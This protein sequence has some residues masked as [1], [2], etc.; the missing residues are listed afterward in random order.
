M[1]EGRGTPRRSCLGAKHRVPLTWAVLLATHSARAFD[2]GTLEEE[3]VSLDITNTTSVVYNGDNRDTRPNTVETLVNDDWGAVLNR[4]N[5]QANWQNFRAGLRLDGAYYYASPD[6]TAIGLDLTATRTPSPLP[7]P[8]YFRQ[9]VSEA[10][11]ERSNRYIN[12]LYPAKYYLGYSTEHVEATVGDFYAQL[13]RG[14][15]LSL[16]K[17]D[18]LASDTTAR[19]ARVTGRVR[20]GDWRFEWTALGGS[21][22]PLRIDD[23]SGRYLGVDSSVTPGFLRWTEAGM[24]RA[25]ETDF[26]PDTGDCQT[27]ATCGYAPDRIAAGQFEFGPKSFKLGT[28]GSLL[29]RQAPLTQDVVRTADRI[30]TGSQ[31]IDIPRLG[32][33]TS[34][35]LEGAFQALDHDQAPENDLSGYAVYGSLDYN[36]ERFSLTV[37]GKHYRRFFPLSANVSLARAREFS[38]VQYSAPPTTEPVWN[39]TQ[40]EGFNTCVTGGRAQGDV[41]LSRDVSLF[42]SVGRYDTWAESV[43]NEG[44]VI[45]DENLNRVWD[46]ASGLEIASDGRKSK[47]NLTLGIRDDQTA[48]TVTDTFGP[49]HV[50]YRESYARYDVVEWLEGP[51]SLQFQGFHRYRHQTLGGPDLPWWEGQHL[52]AVDLSKVANLAVGFE[53]DTNPR[54]PDL[55]F[56]SQLTY[57]IDAGSNLTLFFGQR[58]GALRCVAGVC[59][60]FPPFEGARL[61]F[62]MRL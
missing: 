55:Y 32:D 17:Q 24:P 57:R 51:W 59:R 14:L 36:R 61:D 27:F 20:T 19:G 22:N 15:V 21:T 38:G 50:F 12:W 46:L 23:A 11:V 29:V 13:G 39:D 7:D 2:A 18:E 40:F 16:R 31:S 10:G 49:T 37:E 8:L 60:V 53:Y 41:H 47:S 30:L 5:A 42:G 43:V 28:Q 4:L 25:V 6:P 45:D 3:P 26:A 56:N 58:R 62:T 35:Y 52:T 9:K 44:C 33:S 34:V 54:T 1:T 48:R